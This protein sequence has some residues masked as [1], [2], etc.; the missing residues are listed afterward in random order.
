MGNMLF[1]VFVL[2]FIGNWFFGKIDD[3]IYFVEIREFV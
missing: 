1:L 3:G 2:V